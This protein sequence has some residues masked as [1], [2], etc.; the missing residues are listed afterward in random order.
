MLVPDSDGNDFQGH[1]VDLAVEQ[2]EPLGPTTGEVELHPGESREVAAD[3]PAC[4]PLP[5]DAAMRQVIS[6]FPGCIDDLDPERG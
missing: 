4:E 5:D 1:V 3:V 2:P 6:D